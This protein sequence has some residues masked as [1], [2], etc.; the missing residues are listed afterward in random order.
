[1]SRGNL[2]CKKVRLF[3][4]KP[5]FFNLFSSAAIR[6]NQ[7]MKKLFSRAFLLY[8]LFIISTI[9][10]PAFGGHYSLVPPVYAADEF[11]TSY[12]VLYEVSETGKTLVTQNIALT[13]KTPNFYATE[14]TLTLGTTQIK[15]VTAFDEEG[16]ILDKV[17]KDEDKTIIHIVFNEKIAG[18]GNILDWKLTFESEDAAVK[19]GLVWEINTPRLSEE[20]KI[21]SYK[22]TLSVPLSFHE[23]LYVFPNPISQEISGNRQYFYFDK[24]SLGKHGV[25]AAFGKYQVFSFDLSYH[26]LNS[27]FFPVNIKIP[28]PP[29]TGYQTI[30]LDSLE[31]EPED[32]EVDKDGNWLAHYKIPANEELEVAARGFAKIFAKSKT[33]TPE[34]LSLEQ[35]QEYLKEKKYWESGDSEIKA[36]AERL[37]T[38]GEIYNFVIQALDYDSRRL[39][40][41]KIKRRGALGALKEPSTSICME[42]ADL[43]ITLCR[44]AG[45][46]ARGLSGFAYTTDE[47]RRPLGLGESGEDVLHAWA[48]YYDKERGWVPVD[49]TWEDTTNGVDFFNKLDLS[50][51]VFVIHGFSSEQPFPP[52]SYKLD[53]AAGQDVK[54]NF[55]APFPEKSTEIDITFDFPESVIS[56]LPFSGRVVLSQKGNSAYYPTDFE[57]ESDFFQIT[58]QSSFSLGSLPPFSKKEFEIFLKSPKINKS[59][60]ETLVVKYDGN[61][62]AENVLVKP[63][64]I[65]LLPQAAVVGGGL[66]V[67]L[68]FFIVAKKIW[69][70]F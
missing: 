53:S 38:P 23:L 15:N 56:G 17:T 4:V 63:F 70:R 5:Q 37:K 67:I 3:G 68:L 44:A 19:N 46:P 45:I 21:E 34:K 35:E 2:L 28:F 13:N 48:E 6:Y 58:S 14:Y 11:S 26:L 30:I 62:Y 10:G 55:S 69:P 51:F 39:T 29:D 20:T 59:E 7:D 1:M 66:F 8:S 31:P 43:F 22:L 25:S 65:S 36:L 18:A 60:L 27:N 32:V 9:D 24:V 16:P 64:L 41:K 33:L 42:F 47:K 52:G 57:I 49:P 12:D 50:H 54:V 61:P 40:E